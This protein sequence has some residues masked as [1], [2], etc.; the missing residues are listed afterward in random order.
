MPLNK[1]RSSAH[2]HKQI[3]KT[4]KGLADANFDEMMS[5]DWVYRE[6]KRQHPGASAKALRNAYVAK[7]WGR[8][9]PAARA[10]L[11]LMLREPID[12]ELKEEIIEVLALDQTLM[13]G[14]ANPMAIAGTVQSRN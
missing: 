6:W 7:F 14:R 4:A 1:S 9:I 10:T 13:K 12:P 2:C 5:N 3:A 11:A 8:F